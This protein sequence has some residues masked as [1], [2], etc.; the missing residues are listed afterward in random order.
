MYSYLTFKSSRNLIVVLFVVRG[1]VNVGI[2]RVGS[3][4]IGSKFGGNSIVVGT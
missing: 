3:V 1:D 4:R 2:T